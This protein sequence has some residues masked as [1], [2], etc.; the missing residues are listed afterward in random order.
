MYAQG[1]LNK[2]EGSSVY[3]IVATFLGMV[4]VKIWSL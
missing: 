3:L 1:T 2:A 4:Q